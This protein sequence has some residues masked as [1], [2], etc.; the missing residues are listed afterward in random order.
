MPDTKDAAAIPLAQPLPPFAALRAFEALVR[1]GGIRKAARHLGVHYSVVSRHVASLNALLGVPLLTWSQNQFSLTP[2]GERYYA[3]IAAAISEIA[4]AT[5]DI[6]EPE[7]GR[8]LR[9]WCSPGLSTQWLAGQ[10]TAFEGMHPH[11]RVEIKPSDMPANLHAHEAEANIYLHLDDD[12]DDIAGPGL[13]AQMLVRPEAMLAVSPALA[14]QLPAIS[15][16]HELVHLPLLHGSRKDE[17]RSWLSLQGV[18]L[19]GDPPGELCWN[20]HM[21]LE[22]A[23]LGRGILLANR[24]FF[25]RDL[26]RGDLV[27]LHIPGTTRTSIGSYVFV[28][29][30]DR[31]TMPALAT[32]RGF[33]TERLRSV[34]WH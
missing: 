27:E 16:P 30:E 28:M 12:I 25:E 7:N 34:E 13:K 21:A 6:A 1:L 2:E 5:R 4:T 19:S 11:I 3:H 9:I 23:R 15:S 31:W 17:W 32:L 24:I 10:I 29:R 8:P 14:S 26:M 22:A 33:I 18:D 20:H